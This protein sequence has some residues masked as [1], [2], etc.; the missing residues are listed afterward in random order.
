MEEA[1]DIK[2]SDT[3]YL[4]KTFSLTSDKDLVKI[5]DYGRSLAA[6]MG[7]NES[8]RTII[9]T[10]L[11]EICRNVIEYAGNGEVVIERGGENNNCIIIT[12]SD[13]GPGIENVNKAL[14]EGYSSGMGLGIGLPGAKYIMDKFE[15]QTSASEGTTIR[16]CKWL[17]NHNNVFK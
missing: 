15:I 16:M 3:Q 14:E 5:R 6:N 17:K 13:D 9:S 8:D 11:S 10:A 7:F 1:V 12:I 4:S 2:Q